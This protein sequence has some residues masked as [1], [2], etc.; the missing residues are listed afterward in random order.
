MRVHAYSTAFR[1]SYMLLAPESLRRCVP[2]IDKTPAGKRTRPRA[3][4]FRFSFSDQP[5]DGKGHSDAV[6][7]VGFDARAAKLLFAGPA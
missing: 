2:A 5:G 6:I 1:F 3:A 4:D 7:V